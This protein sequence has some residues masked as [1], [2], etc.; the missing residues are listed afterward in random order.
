MAQEYTLLGLV[1]LEPGSWADWF[2]G[3]MS[4]L[5]VAV[6]LAAYPISKRQRRQEDR[7]RD[8]E[9]AR[10]IGWKMLT[11]LNQNGDVERHIRTSLESRVPM[12]PPNM[13]FPLVRPLG[14]PDRKPQELNQSETDLLLRTKSAELL[15]DLEL[16]F[17]RYASIIYG[18]NEYKVRHEALYELM[19][20]PSANEGMVF[21][22]SL[23]KE[24]AARVKPYTLML[25]SLLDGMIAMVGENMAK[26]KACLARYDT[27]MTRYFG[28]A[29]VTFEAEPVEPP[30]AG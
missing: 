16:C 9:I 24:E 23:T 26:T 1:S 14:V 8:R 28:K 30:L 25:E 11:L 20:T 7:E 5:A 3:S 29:P 2:A 4:A 27:D 10:G 15:M 13:K 12:Y 18:M 21:T 6:A 17:G 19:P 22:H